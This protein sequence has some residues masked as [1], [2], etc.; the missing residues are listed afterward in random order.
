M[1]SPAPLQHVFIDFENV[2]EIAPAAFAPK[3]ASYVLLLGSK[4]R[5][6]DA[7]LLEQLLQHA[8]SV[9][10]VRLTS[11]GRNALDFTLAYYVGRAVAAD[12]TGCFHIVSRDKGYDPLIAHLKTRNIEA[13]RIEDFTAVA[14]TGAA[15]PASAPAPARRTQPSAKTSAAAKSGAAPQAREPLPEKETPASSVFGFFR[16]AT[17]G[18]PAKPAAT[19]PAR[20]PVSALDP[21]ATAALEILRRPTTNRPRSEAKL[22]NLLRSQLSGKPS[23]DEVKHRIMTLIDTGYLDIDGRGRVAYY[24]E[25]A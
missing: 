8:A 3:T 20:P 12:P 25:R 4:Q 23:E 10:L 11:P 14:V 19:P 1:E 6:L 24:F 17:P 18:R 15:A 22:I 13:R 9:E 16:R 2:Q 7:G 21:A 5:K